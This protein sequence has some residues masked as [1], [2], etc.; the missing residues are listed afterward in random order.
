LRPRPLPATGRRRSRRGA[1]S[2]GK[3]SKGGG[4][5]LRGL[6]SL[7]GGAAATATS[8]SR[9]LQECK[10]AY[11]DGRFFLHSACLSLPKYALGEVDEEHQHLPHARHPSPVAPAAAPATITTFSAARPAWFEAVLD[12]LRA[13]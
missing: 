10:G 13:L 12:Q 11:K 4:D 1:A 6:G 5:A 2:K 8:L 3:R 7:K 9:I